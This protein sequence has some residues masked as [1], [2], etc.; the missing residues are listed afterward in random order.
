MYFLAV[1]NGKLVWY[2]LRYLNDRWLKAEQCVKS[3]SRPKICKLEVN[4]AYEED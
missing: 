3:A 2:S 1:I 4:E